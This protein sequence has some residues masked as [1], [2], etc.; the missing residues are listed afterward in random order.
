M[1][2]F[3]VYSYKF[4]WAS[5]KMIFLLN[6]KFFSKNTSTYSNENIFPSYY[7][8]ASW[9]ILL[10]GNKI[11]LIIYV[12]PTGLIHLYL[13]P[14]F[15]IPVLSYNSKAISGTTDYYLFSKSY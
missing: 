11:S 9:F 15:I 6:S 8:N 2:F 10:E 14:K 4:P 1:I 5:I 13:D 12:F 7:S 3:K